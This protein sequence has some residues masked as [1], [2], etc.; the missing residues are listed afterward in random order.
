MGNCKLLI[1]T[2][3]ILCGPGSLA[4]LPH[5]SKPRTS[6]TGCASFFC[7]KGLT[8]NY[9]AQSLAERGG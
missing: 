8:V 5:A 7:E 9:S 3:R 2:S 4:G 1:Y 6:T